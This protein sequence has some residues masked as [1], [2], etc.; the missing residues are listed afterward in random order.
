MSADV[1]DRAWLA[2]ILDGPDEI[3][4]TLEDFTSH[5]QSLCGAAIQALRSGD[6]RELQ[7]A[8]HSLKGSSWM[9]GARALGAAC[10]A[11]ERAPVDQARDLLCRVEAELDRLRAELG[12]RSWA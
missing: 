2:D 1:L 3:E 5:A 9:V 10:E 8:A 6:H 11:L 7:R 4:E 12:R